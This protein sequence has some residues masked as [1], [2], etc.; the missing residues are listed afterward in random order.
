MIQGATFRVLACFQ[1]Q[2]TCTF[3]E[4]CKRSGYPTDLGG[5][6]LRQ[7]TSGGYVEK[8]DRGTYTVSPKGKQQLA[9][10]YGKQLSALYPRLMVLIVPRQGET[11]IVSRRTTQPFIDTYEW[12]AGAVDMGKPLEHAA[13]RV[14]QKRLGCTGALSFQGFFRRID[15]YEDFTFDD[16]LFAVYECTLPIE[17]AVNTHS[18]TGK[19]IAYNHTALRTLTKPS[20]SLLDILSFIENDTHSQEIQY[21]LTIE[22]L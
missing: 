6:Y 15:N 2:D 9:R 3:T 1:G 4:L 13:T 18:T 14:T 21:T 11:Y 19:N 5:Y 10:Y 8:I 22:D 12:P 20:K 7:L 16:K 17:C